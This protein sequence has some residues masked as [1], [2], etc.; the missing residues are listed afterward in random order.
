MAD[1]LAALGLKF[2]EAAT[3]AISTFALVLSWRTAV[4]SGR[5]SQS[6]LDTVPR[7]G[8]AEARIAAMQAEAAHEQTRLQRDSDIIQ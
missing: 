8:E 3:I 6:Q 4:R 5:L 7:Q 1:L 2:S